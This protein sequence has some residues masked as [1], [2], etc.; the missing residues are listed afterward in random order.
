MSNE[1]PAFGRP[2]AGPPAGS[3][4][5]PAHTVVGGAPRVTGD[6]GTAGNGSSPTGGKSGG[7]GGGGQAGGGGEPQRRRSA[8]RWIVEWIVIIL[9]AVGVAFGVRTYV[10]QTYY[11]PSTSMW[12]TLKAGDRIV[13]NKLSGT[14]HVGDIIVFRRP[15]AEHCGGEPVPDLVKRVVGL[16]G[17]TVSAHTGH[18]YITGKLLNEPWL[19]K[20]PHTYTTMSGTYTVPKGDY[21]V[22]GDNR[23]NSCDS[24]M[25]GPVKASYVVGKVFLILW[26][27]S[28]FRYF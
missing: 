14:I 28:Q 10:A 25:W 17:Q 9:V 11:V 7:G 15:P 8:R 18:V 19:P 5:E 2:G 12:P 4:A 22:M 1:T 3:V 24:R 27:P 6:A 20:G 21:F 13:V 26:P 16:P 23:V